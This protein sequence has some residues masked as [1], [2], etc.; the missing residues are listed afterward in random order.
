MSTKA[1]VVIDM[2]NDFVTGSLKC[3]RAQRIIPPLQKL[4]ESARSKGVPVIY[5]N[6]CHYP[7]IDNELKLW[8]EHAIKGTEGA[9]VIKELKPQKED[10]IIP[11]RRYSGFFQ[12]DLHL[13]LREL[14]TE[15]LIM[16][17]LHANMCVRHT[18]ADA[19]SW[20]FKIIVPTDGTDAFTEEDYQGGLAYL[21]QVYGADIKTVD[22]TIKD[23]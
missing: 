18:A 19:F 12:T 1:V 14:R 3:D 23:F 4:L 5:S 17:G 8:G 22:D 15:T 16:T 7:G 2:L 6:D 21:K 11:K 9:E 20:G 10:F 13:L